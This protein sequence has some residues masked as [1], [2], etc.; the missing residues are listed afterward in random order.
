MTEKN[1]IN[2][3]IIRIIRQSEGVIFKSNECREQL[4]SKRTFENTRVFELI[5]NKFILECIVST[6]LRISSEERK[7]CRVN[8]EGEK[9]KWQKD[10]NEN[11]EK[12]AVRNTT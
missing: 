2:S 8:R 1:Y 10:A 12:T 5:T 4:Q 3:A 6:F 11:K 9:K 7:K